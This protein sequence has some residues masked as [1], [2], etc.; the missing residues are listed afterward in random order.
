MAK[1][2]LGA[3]FVSLAILCACSGGG[4]GTGLS[5]IAPTPTP[6]TQPATSS[7]AVTAGALAQVA[8]LA[9]ISSGYS[10]SITVPA[11]SGGAG[12]V[13]SATL[14]SSLPSGIP[15]PQ[16]I[17][18]APRKIGV[19]LTALVYVAVVPSTNVSFASTPG[20]TFSLPPGTSLAAGSAAYVAFFD[21]A[22]SSAGW[23]TVL[24]PGTVSGQTI[25][26]A[27]NP[28]FAQSLTA[29]ATYAY[30][31][32][33]TAQVITVATPTPSPSQ[34]ASP[35]PSTTTFP[36]GG[37]LVANFTVDYP[38]AAHSAVF[39]FTPTTGAVSTLVSLP[40][41]CS[42]T[43]TCSVALSAP[44][45]VNQ[46]FQALLYA[47]ANGTG[48]A[49]AV[50]S[51][52]TSIFA[53]QATSVNI[54]L[55]GI[56][57]TFTVSLNPSTVTV[58]Q[59]TAIQVT[60]N[61]F[62]AA[63]EALAP[64]FVTTTLSTPNFSV[65]VTDPTNTSGAGGYSGIG[66][67]PIT[68]TVQTPNYPPAT[69]SLKFNAAT[70][71]TVGYTIATA[72]PIDGCKV[73]FYPPPGSSTPA[74]VYTL[75]NLSPCNNHPHFDPNGTLWG[76]GTFGI[77]VDGAFA[78]MFGPTGILLTFDLSGNAYV[79]DPSQNALD[80]YFGSTLMRQI[81]LP[82]VAEGA[83]VDSSGNIYVQAG[84]SIYEYLPNTSGNVLPIAANTSGSNPAIDGAGNV[85]ARI[86]G[87]LG[88][89]AAGT[90]G[91]SA[92]ARTIPFPIATIAPFSPITLQILDSGVGP[93]G[94]V[95]VLEGIAASFLGGGQGYVY[96]APAGSSTFTQLCLC[97]AVVDGSIQYVA[98]PLK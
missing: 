77:N 4:G 13:V 36:N 35:L 2:F 39:T 17:A 19:N 44:V 1:R 62:D 59:P 60:E 32:F 18:R 9:Q 69:A 23:G 42:G 64:G 29:G 40:S 93:A 88:V 92:P 25:T 79:A 90:F 37:S 81:L 91:P 43:A 96:H 45:G 66:S 3:A 80:V 84:A 52:T 34:S 55:A 78:G 58:G 61:A 87:G 26:F 95:Y 41:G 85:Y 50:G 98:L 22:Q 74:R 86:G 94:D 12:S 30:A 72:D 11:A 68:Y 63:G 57:T 53:N 83:A 16:S 21:P 10:G 31:L 70:P 56:M 7:A 8:M 65:V 38:S 75:T 28:A 14:Q 71:F 54:A 51:A 6:V 47:S 5:F 82:G 48:T 89:W 67:G 24:G 27:A 33:S 76:F 46:P 97:V 20:F 15:A 73:T 49:L